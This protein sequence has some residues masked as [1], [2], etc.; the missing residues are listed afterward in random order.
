MK[1]NFLGKGLAFPFRINNRGN[2]TLS[3]GER[4]IEESL[5]ILIGTAP[6]ERIMRPDFG[7]RVHE[8]IFSPNN[9]NTASLA[10]FYVQ[11]ALVKWEPRIREVY[12]DA[13]PDPMNDNALQIDIRYRVIATNSVGNMVF[14]FYLR[15]EE[16]L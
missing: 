9:Q 15:K 11:E 7:C 5:R 10:S 4:S 3:E 8:L 14:P 2:L 13:H 12:V 16:V 6:G 1:R